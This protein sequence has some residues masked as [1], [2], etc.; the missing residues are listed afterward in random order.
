MKRH[1]LRA[2]SMAAIAMMASSWT[3]ASTHALSPAPAKP[4]L[5]TG[6]TL[7]VGLLAGPTLLNDDSLGGRLGMTA[8][9]AGRMTGLLQLTDVELAYQFSRAAPTTRAG[10]VTVMRHGFAMTSGLHPLFLIILGNKRIAYILNAMHIDLGASVQ[11]TT[12][13]QNG[14]RTTRGDL[15]WHFGGGVGIPLQDPN[16]GRAWWLGLR[17]RQI[18]AN[19]DLLRDRIPNVGEHQ[20]LVSLE[21]R[22]NW[23]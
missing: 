6:A 3:L 8:G 20:F 16:A 12:L 23:K 4:T 11:V 13:S 17:Y 15:A 5:Y 19:T 1:R 22:W 21:Y 14:A 7:G 9:V 18:R 2:A 10:G